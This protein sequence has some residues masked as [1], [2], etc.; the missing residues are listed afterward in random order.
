MKKLTLIVSALALVLGL[1]QCA[2]RPNMPVVGGVEPS[3]KTITFTTNGGGGAKGCFDQNGGLLNYAW[4]MNDVLYVYVQDSGAEFT[5]G[6]YLGKMDC[7]SISPDDKYSATFEGT[8]TAQFPETGWIRFVH[9]GSAV[10]MEGGSTKE[11]VDFSTQDGS[12]ETISNKVVAIWDEAFD[13]DCTFVFENRELIVK[14][15]VVRFSFEKFDET[16]NITLDGTVNNGLKVNAHGGVE[17]LSGTSSTLKEIES[18]KTEY[19][20]ALMKSDK[21]MYKFTQNKEFAYKEAAIADGTFYTANADG[22]SVVLDVLPDGALPGAFSVSDTKQVYFSKGNLTCDA[23]ASAT[24]GFDAYQ[25]YCNDTKWDDPYVSH[26][27]YKDY[28]HIAQSYAETETSGYGGTGCFFANISANEYT[29]PNPDFV[30]NGVQGKYR[31]PSGDEMKY[32]FESRSGS[33]NGVTKTAGELMGSA[34]VD[35]VAGYM[36]LPDVFTLPEGL[37]FTHGGSFGYPNTVNNTY[38]EEEFLKMEAAGAVFLPGVAYRDG[39]IIHTGTYCKFLYYWLSDPTI[40][41]DGTAHAFRLD[42]VDYGSCASLHV[43]QDGLLH[44]AYTVRLVCE[45][46]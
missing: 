37:E 5:G 9:C 25:W 19:Y 34:K 10:K 28:E 36:I 14:F 2:K 27:Y 45:A 46:K 15:G 21:L 39:N 33:I 3:T 20:V 22:A 23:A 13:E 32:M 40:G 16:G 24:F 8:F 7:V 43:E 35:G 11:D 41:G 18:R 42:N 29:T 6:D 44:H 38:S 4:D 30:V 17:Y 1:A 12:I 26:F 31:A